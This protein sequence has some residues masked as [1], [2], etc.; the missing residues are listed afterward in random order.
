MC[1]VVQAI[2]GLQRHRLGTASA[3]CRAPNLSYVWLHICGAARRLLLSYLDKCWP[4]KR[5]VP[6]IESKHQL[7]RLTDQLGCMH[8]FTWQFRYANPK[9]S[10][11]SASNLASGRL[12]R[13]MHPTHKTGTQLQHASV[14]SVHVLKL[15]RI[16]NPAQLKWIE[17]HASL[18]HC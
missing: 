7:Y 10:H 3:L 17:E 4:Y 9:P 15:R 6:G 1:I 13:C 8:L 12:C 2:W 18:V 16:I 5:C 14:L 11:V